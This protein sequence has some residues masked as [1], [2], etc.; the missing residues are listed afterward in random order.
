MA[1][2][3]GAAVVSATPGA[4]LSVRFNGT[5]IGWNGLLSPET[6]IARVYLDGVFMAEVDTYLPEYQVQGTVFASPPLADGSHT[7]LIEAT[8]L[9]NSA[10]TGARI[11][12]DSFDVAAPITRF[13]ETDAAVSYVGAWQP[14]SDPRLS[15]GTMR[16]WFEAGSRATF[17]FTGRAVTW[18][19]VRAD[20]GGIANVYVDGVLQ[21][22]VDTY[23]LCG[24]GNPR[25]EAQV[26]MFTASFA[27]AGSHT[28]TIEV[29]GTRNPLATDSWV[30]VDAFDVRP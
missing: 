23:C 28:L 19:G 2:S 7:L 5:W 14:W 8:G 22:Q 18:I 24:S 25:V 20:F 30:M 21:G 29:T 17:T 11:V 3:D 10:S 15:G 6:G 26:P 1:W 12:V 27:E 9:R 13:E 4:Q 16:E